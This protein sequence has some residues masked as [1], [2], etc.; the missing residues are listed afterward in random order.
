MSDNIAYIIP[1]IVLYGLA[2]QKNLQI[3]SLALE[4]NQKPTVFY[5]TAIITASLNIITLV[6]Y[7][8]L[9]YYNIAPFEWKSK[10]I[11]NF[12]GVFA[13]AIT[14][15]A[16]YMMNALSVFVNSFFQAFNF[17]SASFL[18]ILSIAKDLGIQT[19]DLYTQLF[20]KYALFDYLILAFYKL[21]T[22]FALLVLL[23]NHNKSNDLSLFGTEGFSY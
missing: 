15:L 19:S 11:V 10:G 1:A 18:F 23:K 16:N 7:S 2:F 13:L 20:I 14:N 22:C 6:C 5:F 8:A 4:A 21:Y 3:Y 12:I 9:E 17:I